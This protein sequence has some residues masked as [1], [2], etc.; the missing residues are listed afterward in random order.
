MPVHLVVTRSGGEPQRVEIPVSVWFS[1]ARRT[2]VRIAREPAIRMI[3]IDPERE[4][5]DI[6]RGNGMWPR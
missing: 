4:F 5:P 6:D 2:T 1:G 3:E